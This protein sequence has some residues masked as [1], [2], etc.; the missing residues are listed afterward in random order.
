MS[1]CLKQIFKQGQVFLDLF[2]HS[3]FKYVLIHLKEINY[4]GLR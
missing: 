2:L 1:V 3:L 4:I